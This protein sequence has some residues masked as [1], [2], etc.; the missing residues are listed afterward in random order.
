MFFK[1]VATVAMLVW[2]AG[3][4]QSNYS[5]ADV[6]P[7]RSPADPNVASPHT[8]NRAFVTGYTHRTPTEPRLWR[9]TPEGTQQG[10]GS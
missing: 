7:S 4:S 9:H 2:L 10:G 1:S 8:V 6:L 3:C 5:P